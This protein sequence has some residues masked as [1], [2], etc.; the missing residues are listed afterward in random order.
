MKI[1]PNKKIPTLL[2]ALPLLLGLSTAAQASPVTF[3]LNW[4]GASF[5]NSAV[6]TGSVTLDSSLNDGSYHEI[7]LP[8]ANVTALSV[9]VSGA[10]SG[11]GSFILADFYLIIFSETSVLDFSRQLV[12][13]TGFAD[14]SIFG[15]G[16]A[17]IAGYSFIIG[18]NGGRG[19]LL[20]LTSMN[21]LSQPVPEPATLALFAI[22]LAGFGIRR[23]A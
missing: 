8:N 13:Q 14:F 2:L 9:N 5:G 15:T 19:D 10:S 7:Y 21:P 20:L 12:G 18:T 17:P 11:N 16:S 4:S 1:P 6:A 22:G 3:D 23:R